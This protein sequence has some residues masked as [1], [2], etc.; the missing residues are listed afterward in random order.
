MGLDAQ[1]QIRDGKNVFNRT[2]QSGAR[3]FSGAGCHA[4]TRAMQLLRLNG[5]SGNGIDVVCDRI[6]DG[7]HGEHFGVALRD[8]VS[9][10]L[11]LN[12]GIVRKTADGFEL[13]IDIRYPALCLLSRYTMKCSNA[14][15]PSARRL[16]C[17]NKRPAV[18]AQGSSWI[19]MLLDVY[20]DC[21]GLPPIR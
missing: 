14:W 3:R 17:W 2:R 7:L 10:P 9:G 5:F 15:S 13:T 11:T 18:S 6:G 1:S 16:R 12:L 19:Q 4:A 8:E 21:T 20:H